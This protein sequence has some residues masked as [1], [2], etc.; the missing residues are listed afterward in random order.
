MAVWL[1]IDID[2]AVAHQ[3]Q[4]FFILHWTEMIFYPKL[5][6]KLNNET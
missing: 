2:Q 6:F 1:E 3:L 5:C 4:E